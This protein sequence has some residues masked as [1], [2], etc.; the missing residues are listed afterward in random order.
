MAG[1]SRL[2]IA[3]LAGIVIFSAIPHSNAEVVDSSDIKIELNELGEYYLSGDEITFEPVLFNPSSTTQIDNNPSCDYIYQVYNTDNS[4][5]FSSENN[6]RNQFQSLEISQGERV[7]LMSQTWDFS[8]NS[9]A[10]LPTG[11]YLAIVTHSVLET[12]DSHTFQYYGNTT[13]PGNIQ[14]D[15]NLIDISS[16]D[17]TA[18]LLQLFIHN[19]TTEKIEL[20]GLDCTIVIESAL[21]R[22]IFDSCSKGVEL[23]HPYENMYVGSHVVDQTWSGSSEDVKIY[24]SGGTQ[25]QNLNFDTFSSAENQAE[26]DATKPEIEQISYQI[27]ERNGNPHLSIIADYYTDANAQVDYCDLNLM[28]VNDYGEVYHSDIVDFCQVTAEANQISPDINQAE[29][30]DWELL[31]EDNCLVDFGKYTIIVE[32]EEF[33]KVDFFQNIPNDS[34]RCNNNNI[35]IELNNQIVENSLYSTVKITSEENLRVFSDCTLIVDIIIEGISEQVLENEFCNYNSGNFFSSPNGI[36]DINQKIDLSSDL[37]DSDYVAVTHKVSFEYT[38]IYSENIYLEAGQ[39]GV[40]PKSTFQVAGIWGSIALDNGQCWMISAPNS[41]Y[42]L[43]EINTNSGWIPQESWYGEYLVTEHKY[44]DSFCSQF[45]LPIITIDEIFIDEDP[46]AK[47]TQATTLEETDEETITITEIAVYGVTSSSIL[48]TLLLFVSNTESL[49]IPVTSAGLWMLGLIGKT[50]ETSDGRFQRGRLIGYLTA[51]P[52]CHFRAL[53]AALNM[54]NGQ[55]THHLRLLE[56]QELIWRINDGRFVRYYPLNNSLHPGMNPDDL[57]VPPLSPDPK[58]LQGKILTI[59]DD[60]HQL[61]EFPTQAELAKKLAKSQ[62]LISHHL[63]TLQKYG[64]VEK[65]KMGIKNRY[66]LTKEAIF[67]LETDIEYL[68][69]KD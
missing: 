25:S 61:G 11:S 24:L 2:I 8:D 32:G 57:P 19:P 37:T 39:V 55:I 34:S 65:R 38:S 16:T 21:N 3:M 54:S 51:N 13:L 43:K 33:S 67:L 1:K 50:H 44:D 46:N 29:V 6:C 18:H 22:E 20:T 59:L 66:K 49:R 40:N 10:E 14:L 56:N 53:M 35:Q 5:V 17:A 9:G 36:Y 63:R 69:V 7:T 12:S 45:G 64:L 30:Y 26:V 58:S 15:Y 41:A 23:L 52:G 62:Q 42:I 31:N 4:L 48:I 27:T 68:K 28:I 60:E 47:T